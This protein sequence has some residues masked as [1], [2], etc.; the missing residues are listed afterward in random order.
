M[1]IF[2]TKEGSSIKSVIKKEPEEDFSFVLTKRIPESV[3]N[4]VRVMLSNQVKVCI[5][6]R[7][8]SETI[9]A[10]PDVTLISE[11]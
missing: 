11:L 6:G 9:I 10:G 5:M 1:H 8:G 7:K 2:S 3:K 4:R